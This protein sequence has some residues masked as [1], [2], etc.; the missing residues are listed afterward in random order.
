MGIA[1]RCDA[2]VV[3]GSENSSNTR[4]LER[5]AAEAGCPRVLRVNGADELP[6]D[7]HGTVGVTAG[8]SAPDELV[9]AV[10]ARLAPAARG[11]GGPGHRR[12]RVLPAAPG[13][14]GAPRRPRRRRLG[15]GRL[16]FGRGA[17]AR[18][19]QG[20][21]QH[22]ARRSRLRPHDPRCSPPTS[23]PSASGSTSSAPPCGSAGRSCC[24]HCSP[25]CATPVARSPATRPGPGTGSRGPAF[26]LL[27]VTGIWNLF[28]ISFSDRSTAYQV[29]VFVKLLVVAVAG[30]AAAVHSLTASRKV[31]AITG[32]LGGLAS[33]GA[34]WLGVLLRS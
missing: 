8:A 20:R 28:E 24:W 27:L 7:L 29:T 13:A 30:G 18:R 34:L 22:G 2:I 15:R 3:I 1:A 5:L 6:A 12:G 4:A 32:A 10:L 33:L 19:P 11:R 25:C 9:D 17:A 26:A 21:R 23:T 14:A 31:L 16:A